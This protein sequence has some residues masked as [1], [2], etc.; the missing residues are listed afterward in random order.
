MY[1]ICWRNSTFLSHENG[2]SREYSDAESKKIF[3]GK[4][5]FTVHQCLEILPGIEFLEWW[6]RLSEVNEDG[7]GVAIT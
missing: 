4:E 7:G 5:P 6:A 2:V 3:S 1:L